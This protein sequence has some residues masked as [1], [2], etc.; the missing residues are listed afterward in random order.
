MHSVNALRQ[1][2]NK[3]TVFFP[4]NFI[5]VISGSILI[6][7]VWNAAE[8]KQGK[9]A[10]AFRTSECLLLPVTWPKPATVLS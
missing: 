4:T 6:G 8:S 3:L 5:S 10:E 1:G 9:L 7:T 2:I